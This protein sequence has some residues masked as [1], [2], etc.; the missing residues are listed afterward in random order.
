MPQPNT[1]SVGNFITQILIP[2]LGLGNTQVDVA[3]GGTSA[4]TPITIGSAIPASLTVEPQSADPGQVVTI[5]GSGFPPFTSVAS[6]TLGGVSVLPPTRPANS[7]P[8]CRYSQYPM[9]TMK[10]SLRWELPQRP[11]PLPS[12]VLPDDESRRHRGHPLNQRAC[13][14]QAS[15]VVGVYPLAR[16]VHGCPGYTSASSLGWPTTARL[17]QSGR[18]RRKQD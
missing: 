12:P 1:D 15:I 14:G 6:F 9:E 11:R 2:Q 16:A 13:F 3:I 8:A 4:S 10:W 17:L 5:T 18:C 7:Q